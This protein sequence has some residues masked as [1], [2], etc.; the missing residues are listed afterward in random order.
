MPNSTLVSCLMVTL[1][2]AMRVAFMK[3]SIGAYCA[4]TYP[5]KE[6]IIVQ[7]SGSSVVKDEIAA[8]VVGLGRNDIVFVDAPTGMTLGALRN[9]SRGQ[10]RGLVHC[11]WDDDDFFHPERIERQLAA[12]I[13]F[14]GEAV[15]LQDTMQFFPATR[16]LYWTNW[17]QTPATIAPGSIM[18]RASTDIIYPEVG[19]VA[20]RGEDSVICA[21]LLAKRQLSALAGLPHLMV[22]VSH[23]SN[24]WE[25]DH[26]SMLVR[27]LGL[28]QGLL[29][30]R[31]VWIREK[32]A[33]LDFGLEQV[34]VRGPNGVAFSLN[35]RILQE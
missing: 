20:R 28:S 12:L 3:K 16:E 23:G 21:Q 6:L 7:D 2:S 25:N 31:E 5:Y 11:P 27:E 9:F 17:R 14:G 8:F 22:Y 10:A 18:Y 35:S 15:G 13:E 29:R 30:R 24:T 26:H 4:Q 1:H 33:G 19:A 34:T 32:L